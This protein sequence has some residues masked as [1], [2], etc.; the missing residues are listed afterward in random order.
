MQRQ[1]RQGFTLIELLIVIVV[2]LILIGVGF[3]AYIEGM[4]HAATQRTNTVLGV[5]K[6]LFDEYKAADPKMT[7]LTPLYT[8]ANVKLQLV[9]TAHPAT[10]PQAAYDLDQS[11]NYLSA[12]LGPRH[13]HN[14]TIIYAND[15]STNRD[16]LRA[17]DYTQQVMRALLTAPNNREALAKMP[18]ES[19]YVITDANG[20]TIDPPLLADGNG[21]PIYF[22]PPAG[23]V[24]A[25]N[26]GTTATVPGPVSGIPAGTNP[27]PTV[28][29]S[30]GRMHVAP[31][32]GVDPQPPPNRLP[33][34]AAA[35]NDDDLGAAGPT[36]MAGLILPSQT[37]PVKA[38]SGD[39]NE[40]S[41]GK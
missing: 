20:N 4:R 38:G 25:G 18:A 17:I 1:K 7:A 16:T 8:G 22:V 23:L 32:D 5:A 30:D 24:M 34:W 35:G 13:E 6:G 37:T 41:I 29:C 11:Y 26:G 33:F 39:D 28:M 36:T 40:Y 12:C 21:E 31:P 9:D 19:R 3:G 27:W 2:I 15:N 14:W 10:T